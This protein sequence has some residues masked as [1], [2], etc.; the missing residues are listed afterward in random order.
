MQVA[1]RYMNDITL[2]TST[3]TEESESSLQGQERRLCCEQQPVTPSLFGEGL[4]M[5][6]LMCGQDC[7]RQESTARPSETKA[8]SN[9]P[10][11]YNRRVQSLL[12]AGLIAGITPT[13]TRSLLGVD[14]RELVLFP[15]GG[16][17]CDIEATGSE[18]A[19][20]S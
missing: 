11:L 19:V 8:K 3:V 15:L 14:C 2:P 16:D 17:T 7:H 12:T 20:E 5:P 10:T 6:A 18:L 1:W 9:L 13:L 4:L